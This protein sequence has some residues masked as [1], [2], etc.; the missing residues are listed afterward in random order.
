MPRTKH[1]PEEIA[2]I[3]E[4]IYQRDIR[5]K[6]MPQHKGKFLALEINT[7]EYEIDEDD[8]AASERL[9]ARVPNGEHLGLRV[10]YTTA[11]TLSGTMDEEE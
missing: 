4:E 1:S 3:A 10:G 9:R 7:G 11:Y 5:P 2:E 6:V 8:L